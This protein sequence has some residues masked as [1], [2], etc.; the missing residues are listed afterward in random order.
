[1]KMVCSHKGGA[2]CVVSVKGK[3]A[4]S[5]RPE[6]AINA[7]NHAAHLII[8]IEEE[9]ERLTRI[10][11]HPLLGHS[12][13]KPTLI[14]RGAPAELR[15][16]SH[17]PTDLLLSCP[18]PAPLSLHVPSGSVL[19]GNEATEHGSEIRISGLAYKFYFHLMHATRSSSTMMSLG[20]LFF[21]EI[22]KLLYIFLS[23]SIDPVFMNRQRR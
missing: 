22:V 20:P 15:S 23:A 19:L 13:I 16:D 4:H 21:L 7:I 11:N 18:P 2:G 8:E 6:L 14:N 3:A 12:T 17:R 1:M 5:S 9:Q 10:E